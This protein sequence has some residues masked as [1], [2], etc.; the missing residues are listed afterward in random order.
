MHF[1]GNWM[2]KRKKSFWL[3]CRGGLSANLKK[4]VS[5]L[6]ASGLA[7]GKELVLKKIIIALPRAHL[8]ALGKEVFQENKYTF[9]CREPPGGSRQR[10][11]SKKKID[12]FAES[13]AR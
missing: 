3:I 13:L 12:F 7:L 6:R 2:K 5:L 4:M 11:F 10:L 9:L 1:S 8:E